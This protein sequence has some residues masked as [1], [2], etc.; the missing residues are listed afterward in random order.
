MHTAL[1]AIL[2]RV[3]QVLGVSSTSLLRREFTRSIF[4]SEYKPTDYLSLSRGQAI[5]ASK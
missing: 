2:N 5:A 4:M 3:E 1:E